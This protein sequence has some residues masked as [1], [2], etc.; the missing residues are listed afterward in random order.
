MIHNDD[1]NELDEAAEAWDDV[2]NEAIDAGLVRQ[3]RAEELAF[4]KKEQVY[5]KV[6]ME[7]CYMAKGGPPTSVRWI[8]TNKGTKD[9]PNIRCRLVARDFK[10]RGDDREDICAHMPPWEAKKALFAMAAKRYGDWR[11]G[12]ADDVWRVMFIDVKKAHLKAVCEDTCAFVSLPDEDLEEGYCGKLNR[13]LY[14]MRGA[15]HGWEK[16]FT[17]KL[18]CVAGF[19]VGLYAPTVFHH[20][21]RQLRCVVHGDDFTFIGNSANLAWIADLMSQWYEIK[22]RGVLGP[23]P[24]DVKEID[25]LNRQVKWDNESITMESRREARESDR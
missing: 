6:P 21:L 17:H 1:T 16:E 2:K 9:M 20:E 5:T 12:N 19:K 22:M 25:I 8:D 14:G 3:A 4:M 18:T 15:A 24:T 13:W 23:E 7:Q 10:V 11:R